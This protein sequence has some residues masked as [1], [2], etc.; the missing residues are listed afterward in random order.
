MDKTP[1]QIDRDALLA[2]CAQPLA[3]AKWA[4]DSAVLPVGVS[5]DVLAVD[6]A[7]HAS[8][9]FGIDSGVPART[10]AWIR[11]WDWDHPQFRSCDLADLELSDE[12]FDRL[13]ALSARPDSDMVE[14][15]QK[16]VQDAW[17]NIRSLPPIDFTPDE[18]RAMAI[19]IIAAITGEDHG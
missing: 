17:D 13:A 5:V 14:R 8:W 11:W 9:H 1:E 6:P 19:G 3:K 18:R 10:A 7:G 4:G 12:D 15:V 16:A 2:Q